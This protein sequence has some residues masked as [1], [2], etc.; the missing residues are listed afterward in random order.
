MVDAGVAWIAGDGVQV[1]RVVRRLR[2]RRGLVL[3]DDSIGRNFRPVRRHGSR[4]VVAPTRT[5]LRARRVL[6]R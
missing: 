4:S 1:E 3:V 6:G 5:V 2:D